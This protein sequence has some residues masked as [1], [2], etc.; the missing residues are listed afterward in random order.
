MSPQAPP[1]RVLTRRAAL[2]GLAAPAILGATRAAGADTR[3]L[4]VSHQFPASDGDKGDFRDRLLRR[5]GREVEMRTKGALR[6]E[7]YPNASLVKSFAQFNALKR[8][9]IDLSLVPT[10]YAGKDLPELNLTFMPAIV[11]SYDQAYRWKDAPIGRALTR[12]IENNGVKVLTWIWQSGGIASRVN[13]IVRPADAQGLR[14]RGGSREMDLMFKAAGALTATMPSNEIFVA[15]QAGAI[16][17]AAT[18]STSFLSFRLE[19][20][21]KHLMA[22]GGRSFFFIFEP[23]LM[24]AQTFDSLTPEQRTVMV[25]VGAALEE[26]GREAAIADDRAVMDAYRK[27]G[28]Q[29]SELDEDELDLWRGVAA[30]SAWRDFAARSADL[31][32]FLDLAQSV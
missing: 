23:I 5:F 26:A 29:V 19:Q 9:A 3:V 16:D 6:F 21:S 31:A 27:A 14:I 18:S 28:V 12:V 7:I 11:T 4:K 10:T 15:M 32:H 1:R 30:G 17:A 8:G 24:S 13:P 20:L 2:G 22:A 25:E